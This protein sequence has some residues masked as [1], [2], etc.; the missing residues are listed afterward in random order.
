M[1]V[2]IHLQKVQCKYPAPKGG[3]TAYT[4]QRIHDIVP[5]FKCIFDQSMLDTKI[6]ETNREGRRVKGNEWKDVA[7]M[8]MEAYFGQCILHGVFKGNYVS[9]RESDVTKVRRYTVSE[10]ENILRLSAIT[11][12]VY[13]QLRNLTV[14]KLTF[15]NARRGGEP[16]TIL[17]HEWDSA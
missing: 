17:L 16:S 11:S 3:I 4:R 6:V 14:T 9:V 10:M 12:S 15:C 1:Q 8:E 13:V 2:Q 7:S 5:S